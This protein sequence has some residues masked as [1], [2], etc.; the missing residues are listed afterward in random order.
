MKWVNNE[1]KKHTFQKR[2]IALEQKNKNN[3]SIP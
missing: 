3:A 2:K 1:P